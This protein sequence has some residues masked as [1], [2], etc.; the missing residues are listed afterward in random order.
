MFGFIKLNSTKAARLIVLNIFQENKH[1]LIFTKP[2]PS[3]KRPWLII[4]VRLQ[5][6]NL[7]TAARVMK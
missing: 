4:H 7:D 6:T 1:S 5:V 3:L 2:E